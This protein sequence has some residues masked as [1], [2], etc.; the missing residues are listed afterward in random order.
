V[1]IV[2]SKP[3]TAVGGGTQGGPTGAFVPKRNLSSR[4]VLSLVKKFKKSL[5]TGVGL[6]R[7]IATVASYLADW[8]G[9]DNGSTVSPA[10]SRLPS[11]VAR[12]QSG[13]SHVNMAPSRQATDVMGLTGEN[14]GVPSPVRRVG[15]AVEGGSNA[16]GRRGGR[17][18]DASAA[19][20]DN[21]SLPELAGR[22]GGSGAGRGGEKRLLYPGRGVGGSNSSNPTRVTSNHTLGYGDAQ[23]APRTVADGGYSGSEQLRRM[24]TDGGPEDG[25]HRNANS[26][27]QSVHI[28]E[29]A[30]AVNSLSI[31]HISTVVGA[32]SSGP[33]SGT[34]SA[35]VNKKGGDLILIYPINTCNRST[36]TGDLDE[37]Q[38]AHR[39][40]IGFHHVIIHAQ[41][42]SGG[43]GGAVHEVA[44]K[45]QRTDNQIIL[46]LE[47]YKRHLSEISKA[48]LLDAAASL[49]HN[50]SA[51]LTVS[52]AVYKIC[53]SFA[54]E[55]DGLAQEIRLLDGH[56][57]RAEAML[58][59]VKMR[60]FGAEVP[61]VKPPYEEGLGKA[62]G[63]VGGEDHTTPPDS[64]SR[65]TTPRV[66]EEESLHLAFVD[67]L[68]VLYDSTALIILHVFQIYSRLAEFRQIFDALAKSESTRLLKMLDSCRDYEHCIRSFSERQLHLQ[69][70][71]SRIFLVRRTY[72]THLKD[73]TEDLA[74]NYSSS[75]SIALGML[76]FYQS[77]HTEKFVP[78]VNT[79]VDLLHSM[80]KSG[81]SPSSHAQLQEACLGLLPSFEQFTASYALGYEHWA[82]SRE[83]RFL[84]QGGEGAGADLRHV[85]PW[86]HIDVR[87]AVVTARSFLI[88]DPAIER[89]LGEIHTQHGV[90]ASSDHVSTVSGGAEALRHQAIERLA[91]DEAGSHGA[92]KPLTIGSEGKSKALGMVM[93]SPLAS[94][95][96]AGGGR[97][98]IGDG[99]ANAALRP[100]SVAHLAGGAQSYV[101]SDATMLPQLQRAKRRASAQSRME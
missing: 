20:P 25:T 67:D 95:G 87:E 97:K 57:A 88:L 22:V 61:P 14:S 56:V 94:N 101:A 68:K 59:E 39:S 69:E 18:V 48:K 99:N 100:M 15:A 42:E 45:L 26:K 82:K 19:G 85:C 38:D 44:M 83:N 32:H 53:Q 40:K 91:S 71:K 31:S 30:L 75:C 51:A 89:A 27:R 36:D 34:V 62:V 76:L 63:E 8:S 7:I 1:I 47:T 24:G 84:D 65:Y 21:R 66:V 17:E 50:D 93:W 55:L 78:D 5:P 72:Q 35:P 6:V 11:A 92:V 74:L 2:E 86:C 46:L 29:D 52:P 98:R 41:G 13:P 33:R 80:Q 3:R 9:L 49:S 28:P 16:L 37:N 58:N 77:F 73:L 64:T 60:S 54:M 12:G 96:R 70:V 81:G 90:S 4:A 10:R 23:G 43:G 79:L